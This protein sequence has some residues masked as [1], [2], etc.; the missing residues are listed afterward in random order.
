MA[1][2]APTTTAP[3]TTPARNGRRKFEDQLNEFLRDLG[4][5]DSNLPLKADVEQQAAKEWATA[6]DNIILPT[7]T[8]AVELLVSSG[9]RARIDRTDDGRLKLTL[10]LYDAK[11]AKAFEFG[12]SVHVGTVHLVIVDQA[13][14]ERSWPLSV[15]TPHFVGDRILAILIQVAYSR[16]I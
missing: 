5:R 9:R 11:S 6:R 15:A 4:R 8:K 14:D 1:K 16:S 7:L 2:A 12:Y 13:G 10:Q 3:T